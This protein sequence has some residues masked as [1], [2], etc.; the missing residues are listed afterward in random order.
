MYFDLPNYADGIQVYQ[1]ST[2]MH[3]LGVDGR[4][5]IER[6]PETDGTEECLI[7]TPEYSFE[8]QRGYTYEGSY[9]DFPSLSAGD[10]LWVECTYDNT[11]DNEGARAALEDAGLSEPQDV[12]LGDET[13]DEMCLMVLGIT[14]PR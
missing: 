14:Y 6:Q 3:Y 5:W 2:H 7:Q 12:T 9:D 1:A 8:W 4:V 10:R 11:L 13:L